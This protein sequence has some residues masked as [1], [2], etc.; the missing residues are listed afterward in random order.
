[1]GSS[2]YTRVLSWEEGSD[3]GL[4]EDGT[5]TWSFEGVPIIYVTFTR[6]PNNGP[7]AQRTHG[8][9]LLLDG[10]EVASGQWPLHGRRP[11]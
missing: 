10:H 8:L 4:M 9:L 11:G 2:G 7:C 5:G 3:D 6:W 1:M